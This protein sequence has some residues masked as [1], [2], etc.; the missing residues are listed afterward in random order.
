MNNNF[1]FWQKWLL[2][3]SIFLTI[4]GVFIA[5]GSNTALFEVH[6]AAI[7]ETFFQGDLSEEA[8]E[9]RSFLFAPM[10]GTI[11]G[12]FLMQSFIVWRPFYKREV[13]SWHAIFWALLLWFF[14]DSGMS[15]FHGAFFNVWMVN[16]W[17]LFLVGLPL[18]MTRSEFRKKN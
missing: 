12:Y 16:I 7:S 9:L 14:V 6:T 5:V 8:N 4:V 13:W 3:V 1:N 2:T 10:G 11:A 18:W 17:T 15:I